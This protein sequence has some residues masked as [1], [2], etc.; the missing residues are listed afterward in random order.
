MKMMP[1]RLP[2]TLLFM[3][4]MALPLSAVAQEGEGNRDR[5][6][7]AEMRERWENASEEEREQMREEMRKRFEER[8]AERS[9]QQA[10]ALRERL[11]MTEEDYEAIAPLIGNVRN[12]L[13]ER[14]QATRGSRAGQRGGRTGGADTSNM[15]DRAKAVTGAMATLREAMEKEDDKA[16]KSG[17]KKLRDSRAAMDKAVS[18][19]REELRSICSAKWE[20]EFVVM[21]LL[22]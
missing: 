20:A 7:R 2:L 21:G 19:A 8:N 5:G 9:K 17:L 14:E 15:S 3:I 10:E 1:L 4:T 22:D 12:L 11:G 18:E 16:I 13:R 6:S